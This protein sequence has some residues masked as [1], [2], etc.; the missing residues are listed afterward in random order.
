MP[1][2]T[3]LPSERPNPA[4]EHI[5]A[6]STEELLA[7][8]NAEDA[9]VAKA[10]EREVPSIARALDAIEERYRRGGRL[11]YLGAGT[12]G[13]LGV[14]DASEIPPTF[15]ES[16]NRIV[17]VI[18]GGAPALVR[19]AEGREDSEDSGADDLRAHQFSAADALVGIAASGRTP[20]VIGGLRYARELGAV[21]VALTTNPE[22]A[23]LAHA[24]YPV[25]PQV[26]PEVIAGS[27]R[28]KSGTAQKLVLNM[29]STGLMVRMGRVLGNRMVNV[30]PS[31]EKLR[32]RAQRLIMEIAACDADQAQ[33]ALGE[34][35]DVRLAVLMIRFDCDLTQA[36][37]RLD[38]ADGVLRR[39]LDIP[40]DTQ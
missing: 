30:R 36:R 34:A 38:Q 31:N 20:Y 2:P 37:R 15:G 17:G 25:T 18:A 3:D 14:L 24:D 39:A 19:S 10:V 6:V 4:S 23:M 5:D 12:S 8:I 16:P 13:R 11:F 27:T 21:T 28:M 22:A 7:I 1:L 33:K 32:I 29:L 40:A 9:L 35:D 26:G